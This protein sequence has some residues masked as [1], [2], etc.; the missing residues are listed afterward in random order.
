MRAASRRVDTSTRLGDLQKGA[1]PPPLSRQSRADHS[2]PATARRGDRIPARFRDGA[3]GLARAGL[4]APAALAALAALAVLLG[5]CAPA[6]ARADRLTFDPAA[7]YRAPRG[8]AHAEGPADAPV[9]IVAW[10]D[11]TCGFCYRAQ[12]T[13]DALQRLYP[14]QLRLVHRW[15]PLDPD[16]TV[17]AEAAL[18]AAAQGRF[19]PMNDRIFAVAGRVDRAGLELFARELGL[20]MV[21]FRADLDAGRHRAQIDADARDAV[22]LGL[23]GTPAFFI[24]GRALPGDQPLKAFTDVIDEELLRAARQGVGYDALVATG[25]PTA[26]V[27]QAERRGFRFAADQTYK[28]GLGLPGHQLGPDDALVT[29]VVW[30]DL[31][32]A[33]CAKQAPILAQVRQRYG[34]DVRLVYRHLPLWGHPQ[35]ALA[36]EAAVAAA[37]QGKLWAFHDAVLAHPGQLARA[38][39]EQLAGAAGIDLP[40]LRAAL[41]DRRH[42]D[43]VAAEGAEAMALGVD[44]TPTLFVNGHAVVGSRDRAALEQII[45]E[46]LARARAIA[47]RGL[48]ARD[49]YAV[50]M[51]GAV[52]EERAD[53]STVPDVSGLHVALRSD[54]LARAVAAACRR[55]DSRRAA[56]LSAHLKGDARRR[57]GLV[58]TASGIDLP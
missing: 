1:F 34:A 25:R 5:V 15:L 32:S 30:G 48:P 28:V 41:D 35:A 58:C 29:I 49:L 6:P 14:G 52:G 44:T 37:E 39:L 21:R 46:H 10:S 54:E 3:S 2:R 7:I 33:A 26:D 17:A 47:A 24:N 45:D 43:A 36:A 50:L 55:R 19:R 31:Q 38:D 8:A 22:A 16:N 4:A 23:T 12:H 20:D 56:T 9:T 18:A 42:R 53:P 57:A 51:S 27:P 40:R 13:L 11:H